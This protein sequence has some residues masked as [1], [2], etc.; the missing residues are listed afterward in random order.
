MSDD[1]D[2]PT[3]TLRVLERIQA[4][5]A[6]LRTEMV[7]VKGEIVEMKGEIVEM[8]GEIVEIKGELVDMKRDLREV[9]SELRVLGT[10]FDNF[11]DFAGRD[12]TELEADFGLI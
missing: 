6:G 3:L 2:I 1:R 10:R 8:K 9:K 11:L 5:V 7:E 12:V 4:D